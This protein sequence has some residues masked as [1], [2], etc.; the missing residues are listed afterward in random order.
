MIKTRCSA[1]VSLVALIALCLVS[2]FPMGATRA[3]G[4][5]E[6]VY[7]NLI[8]FSDVID[9]IEKNYVDP[10]E[11]DLLIKK[12]VQGMVRS[13]DPHSAY[14]DSEEYEALH[15][16]TKGEFSGIGVVLTIKDDILTVIS[17]IE[18]TPAHKA[19]I[20]A[21]D[22]I[23]KIN[24]ET[25]LDMSINDAVNRIKGVKGTK[26]TLTIRRKGEATPI[27]YELIRDDIPLES[28]KSVSLAPGYGYLSISN[29]N[30][31]TT[32]DAE[33]AL[34]S[35][36]KESKGMKGLV[37][38]LRGNP[39]GLLQQAVSIADIFIKKGVIVSIRG[40]NPKDSQIWEAHD[41]GNEKTYPLVVLINGGSASASEIVAGALQDH[42]RGLILGTQSFGKGSVQNIKPLGDG[43]ALKLTVARY[44]TPSGRSIQAEGIIPDIDAGYT[45]LKKEAASDFIKEKDLKNHLKSNDEKAPVSP[46]PKEESDE[47]SLS[48]GTVKTES[49]NMR[50]TDDT[51]SK[52]IKVLEKGAKF[53]VLERLENNWLKIV[54]GKDVGYINGQNRYVTIEDE[55]DMAD[56]FGK[57]DKTR[58]LLDSQIKQALDLLISHRIFSGSK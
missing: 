9:E 42:K 44:F 58:L 54:H 51:S 7:K 47:V 22:V 10:V 30:E 3:F 27:D 53:K 25:A 36:E 48:M 1:M 57:P 14:L 31:N 15:E 49:L 11:S 21:G 34:S 28:V 19:G 24:G 32:R 35:L 38:D 17:P 41:G 23:V 12:A 33:K 45:K 55:D 39:G 52:L 40:R 13:L 4:E 26:L 37:F 6:T 20:R 43:S 5:S 8:I 16:D 56:E 18:G 29:F 2:G 50:L 46:S